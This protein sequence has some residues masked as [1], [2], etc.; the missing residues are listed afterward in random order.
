MEKARLIVLTDIGPWEGEPDD[1]QSLVRLM[2]YSNEYDIEGIIP[3]ASWCGP[4]TSDE[5]YMTRITDV[6]HAFGKARDNLLVHADGYPT[7]EYL[8][9]VVK[10]GTSYVNM[11]K[12][13]F[14][15]WGHEQSE[16]VD[17]V[18]SRNADELE[19][20]VGEG[21]SNDGSRLIQKAIEKDDPRPLHISLWGG[22]GTLAQAVYDMEKQYSYDE[23]TKLLSRIIVYD[24]D[25]QD[26]CG[27]WI[28]NKYPNIVWKRSDI[29]FWGFSETPM[30]N[31]GMFGE[32]CF[33]GN[34]EVVSP[35]WVKE[36]MQ[37]KGALGKVY[38]LAHF[39]LETDSPSILNLVHNGLNDH[40]HHHWGGW[41]GRHTLVKSQNVPAEHF[42]VTY[43]YE[44]R[45]YYMYRD[46]V[47]TWYDKYSGKMMNKNIHGSI[48]RWRVD[49][50]NDMAVRML[51][52]VN[53]KY[54]N[55]NHAPIAV[56]DGDIS[57][58]IIIKNVSCGDILKPDTTGTSDPDGDELTFKWYVYPE[59]G[60]YYGEVLIENANTSSPVIHVP[61]DAVNDEIHIIL[62]V[63]DNGKD[64]PL[65]AYRRL[66]LRTGET[67][68][69]KK[70]TYVNDT[71]FEYSG[72]WEYKTKQYGS[73]NGDIHLSDKAGDVATLKFSGNRIM[74]FGGAFEDNGMAEITIDG[75][76]SKIVDFYSNIA[77]WDDEEAGG[78]VTTGDTLQYVSPYLEDGEHEIQIKVLDRK[79]E[80]SLGNYIVIDKAVIF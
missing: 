27:A 69:E 44:N 24:I 65:K 49:Y 19:D 60:T 37:S 66:V 67:G 34:L 53:D 9:S 22:C 6:V 21:L 5:G 59:A 73:H 14:V 63:C 70:Q 46:D 75:K 20:N 11:K 72:S 39:G 42:N 54:E 28:C 2:L 31:K 40:I 62:E 52:S 18:K 13:N 43:L 79:N 51:W 35:E 47:D 15:W 3:N 36:N 76:Y 1:A 71:D 80:F 78:R 10:R 50:Q 56:V 77:R 64:F 12:E 74:L 29:S 4:D 8:L 17:H 32:E 57:K 25:G 38:P 16:K 68:F 7:E 61:D 23:M 30:K 26:D 41:G 45:P 55:C 33:V 58:D 48:A